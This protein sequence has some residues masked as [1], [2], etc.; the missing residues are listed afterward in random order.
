MA[1]ATFGAGLSM[2]VSVC[3]K[4]TNPSYRMGFLG[5]TPAKSLIG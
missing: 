4:T 1:A 5:K 3:P 2:V